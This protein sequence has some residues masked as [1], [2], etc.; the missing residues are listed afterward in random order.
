MC[1]C[2]CVGVCV[3]I[4]EC[5]CASVGLRVSSLVGT[6]LMGMYMYCAIAAGG[7]LLLQQVGRQATLEE[8]TVGQRSHLRPT[9]RPG[10]EPRVAASAAG[11]RERLR[12]N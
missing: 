12:L 7:V 2:V 1:V 8:Q 6:H 11:T 5:M 4:C 10:P 9:R 3:C